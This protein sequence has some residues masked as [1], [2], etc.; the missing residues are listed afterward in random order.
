MNMFGGYDQHSGN[1]SNMIIWIIIL[2]YACCLS[3]IIASTGYYNIYKP[4]N[5]NFKNLFTNQDWY[6]CL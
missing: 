3:M 4:F 2:I 6:V 1:K 5:N